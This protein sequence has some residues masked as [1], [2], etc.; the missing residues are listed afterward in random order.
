M[1]ISLIFPNGFL[2]KPFRLDIPIHPPLSI[3]YL[4]AYLREQKHEVQVID[5]MAENLSL[6][7]VRERLARFN[8]DV[9]GITTNVSIANKAMMTAKYLRS[10]HV[11]VPIIMG[12]AWATTEYELILRHGFADAVVL[13]EGEITLGELVAAI[14]DR[15]R[16]FS[17]PGLTFI[18]D[19]GATVI[20]TARPHIE[21]LD[22][23]PFPAWDIFPNNRRY[24]IYGRGY[25]IY[26]IMTSR[27]CPYDCIH[28]TKHVHGY[29][30]RPRSAE[31]VIDEIRFLKERFHVKTILV[32]DDNF[33]CDVAR[34]ERILDKIIAQKLNDI[35]YLCSNGIRADTVS[36]R[37]AR[38]LKE[39]GFFYIGIGIE[40][41]NQA[42]V[43]AIGKKLDLQKVRKAVALLKEQHIIVCGYFIFGL[44]QDTMKT[45][46]ETIEFAKQLKLDYTQFFKAV[47]IPGTK[48]YDM[49]V[50]E[51][52]FVNVRDGGDVDGYNVSSASFEIGK[53]KA[54]DVE[55]AFKLSYNRFYLSPIKL[56][57]LISG[58]RSLHEANW[59]FRSLVQL[60]LKTIVPFA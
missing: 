36:P 60:F 45:M 49:I 6:D 31:N 59:F 42:I 25:P 44:P 55:R 16:W 8:P 4:A 58:I 23:L 30:F 32:A 53:L 54:E 48:M 40:S 13:G 28:C 20:T 46:E 34:C 21:D 18:D 9:I 52:H 50:K 14:H 15:S 51:G 10:V 29:K 12:G 5:A 7:K 35:H 38:K 19:E 56:L 22:S 26:P 3:A 1:K 43:K 2:G 57:H 33:T 47:P 39:A 27:G 17:I 24:T 37:L 41:G 11:T